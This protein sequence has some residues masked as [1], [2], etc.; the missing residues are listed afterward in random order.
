MSR[1]AR[2]LQRFDMDT[3]EIQAVAQAITDAHAHKPGLDCA[4]RLD[5][6]KTIIA[7]FDAIQRHRGAKGKSAVKEAPPAPAPE[8]EPPA[9]PVVATPEPMAPA[10]IQDAPVDTPAP[11]VTPIKPKKG[12]KG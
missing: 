2:G 9:A 4:G 12:K 1:Q 8:T 3:N 6:A 5:D 7:A 10:A 11:N